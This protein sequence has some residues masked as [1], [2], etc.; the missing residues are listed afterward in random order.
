M[1]G[2]SDW[3]QVV[4]DGVDI[5]VPVIVSDFNGDGIPDVGVIGDADLAIF[6]GKGNATY[7][8][9]FYVGTGYSSVVLPQNLRGQAPS[10]GRPD[11]SVPLVNGVLVLPNITK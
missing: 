3:D 9:P 6:T 10:A 5:E 11:L 4:F 2:F 8:P 1:H 7:E